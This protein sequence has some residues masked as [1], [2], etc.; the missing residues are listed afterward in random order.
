MKK[1]FNN[2]GFTLIE[3]LIAMSIFVIFMGILLGSYSGIIVSQKK[4]NNYRAVYEEGRSVFDE[5]VTEFRENVVDYGN[6]EYRCRPQVLAS[7]LSSVRLIS[8]DG[9]TRT[10]VYF[11][12]G[13]LKI[14]KGNENAV[15]LNSDAALLRDFKVYVYPYVDPYDPSY[16]FDDGYQFQPKVT[17]SAIF[18]P[19]GTEFKTSVSSRLYNQVYLTE[20]CL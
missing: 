15:I 6:V 17:F 10:N 9:L 1:T 16:V 11:E 14:Q 3:I 7:A 19:F 2:K 13:F 8:R 4:A 18:E 12:D 5:L 20:P